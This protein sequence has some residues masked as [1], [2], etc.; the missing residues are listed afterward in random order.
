M[1]D[2]EV[3][4]RLLDDFAFDKVAVI[5]IDVE[6]HESAVLRGAVGTLEK[7]RPAVIVEVEDFRMPGC[8]DG[9]RDLMRDLRYDG[10]YICHGK[11]ESLAGF[12]VSRH[13]SPESRQAYGEKRKPDFV[14]NF[15]F[16][17]REGRSCLKAGMEVTLRGPR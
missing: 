14:N 10:F 4:C 7:H 2:V 6:G 13:Q 3:E 5:K 1:H 15:L 9:I 8:F 17:P 16:Q 11:I 12:D